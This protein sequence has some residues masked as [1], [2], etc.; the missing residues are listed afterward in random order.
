[1]NSSSRST[2]ELNSQQKDA[3]GFALKLFK[4]LE[5]SV[6][7]KDA[8]RCLTSYR[9]L[10]ESMERMGGIDRNQIEVILSKARELIEPVLMQKI[11]FLLEKAMEASRLGDATACK[12]FSKLVKEWNDRCK[13]IIIKDEFWDAVF[14]QLEIISETSPRGTSELARKNALELAQGM[15]GAGVLQHPQRRYLRYGA[16]AGLLVRFMPQPEL[17]E[18]RDISMEGIQTIGHPPSLNIGKK[19][20]IE[21]IFDPSLTPNSSGTASHNGEK[22][23]HRSMAQV[24]QETESGYGLFFEQLKGPILFLIKERYIDLNR[25]EQAK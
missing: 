18:L 24:M 5:R 12:I 19:I 7:D 25:L 14:K 21:M 9:L 6:D 2:A 8:D 15:G 16:P 1:M 13:F 17:F 3:I 23:T 20:Q 4:Q 22:I 10:H 11:E